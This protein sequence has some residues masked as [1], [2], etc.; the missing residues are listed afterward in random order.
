MVHWRLAGLVLVAVAVASGLSDGHLDRSDASLART[1]TTAA[2]P[3]NASAVTADHHDMPLSSASATGS[4]GG[5]LSVYVPPVP[6]RTVIRE[7]CV[8]LVQGQQPRPQVWLPDLV[9]LT[10]DTVSATTSWCSTYLELNGATAF[11]QSP[12]PG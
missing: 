4:V 3:S 5:N 2:G 9:Q 11:R 1:I 8:T 7:L 12:P 10:G 6:P